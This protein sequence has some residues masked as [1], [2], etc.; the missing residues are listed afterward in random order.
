MAIASGGGLPGRT[1][2]VICNTARGP[3]HTVA[4]SLNYDDARALQERLDAIVKQEVEASGKV[5]SSWTAK[6][7]FL[8]L[9][10]VS[11]N[12]ENAK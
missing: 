9:E 11:L 5:Y 2:R 6:L 3:D 12:I 10:P 7:H 8:E 1:Y 4:K